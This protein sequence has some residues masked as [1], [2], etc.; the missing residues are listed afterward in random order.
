LFFIIT[1]KYRRC[2]S[3]KFG[4]NWIY[5]RICAGYKRCKQ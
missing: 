3:R 5:K 4:P 2:W 1:L